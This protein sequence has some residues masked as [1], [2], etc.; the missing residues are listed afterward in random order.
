[1]RNAKQKIKAE[2]RLTNRQNITRGLAKQIAE[3]SSESGWKVTLT[4]Q[5]Y[6]DEPTGVYTLPVLIIET[7][8]GR[9]DLEPIGRTLSNKEAVELSAW[10][11]SYRVRLVYTGNTSNWT[12]LTDSGIPLHEEW[13]KGNFVR[14]A[15]DLVN[16]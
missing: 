8:D 7:P 13:S 12:V 4:E 14:L 9:V 10:P 3:W 2:D 16:A 1:M 5:E 6:D 11:T 15:L